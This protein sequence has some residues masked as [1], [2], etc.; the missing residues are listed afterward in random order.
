MAAQEEEPSVCALAL[1][2]HFNTDTDTDTHTLTHTN[3]HIATIHTHT[4]TLALLHCVTAQHNIT[5]THLNTY[6]GGG[7]ARGDNVNDARVRAALHATPAG[8]LSRLPDLA[9]G[10][11]SVEAHCQVSE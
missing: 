9:H 4:H 11:P 2:T 7:Q 3:L 10:R 6:T 8:A 5:H 1:G